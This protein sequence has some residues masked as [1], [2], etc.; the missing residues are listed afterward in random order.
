MRKIYLYAGYLELYITDKPMDKPYVLLS[1]YRN[2]K[3]A[4]R[5]AEK[6]HP[7]DTVFFQEGL[8]PISFA[9][10]ANEVQVCEIQGR[11]FICL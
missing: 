2:V 3:S 7:G 11:N 10:D 4:E 9:L 6:L 1:T 5:A 8:F